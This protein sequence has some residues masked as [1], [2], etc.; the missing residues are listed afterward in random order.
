MKI[1]RS[2]AGSEEEPIMTDDFKDF[3]LKAWEIIKTGFETYKPEYVNAA[4]N[5]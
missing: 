4:I 2:L 3:Q 5:G 1:V